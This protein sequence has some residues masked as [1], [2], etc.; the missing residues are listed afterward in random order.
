LR[1]RA[2]S[3]CR[4][5]ARPP[6]STRSEAAAGS[7]VC[8]KHAVF[9]PSVRSTYV[10]HRSIYQDRLGTSIRK[11]A[12]LSK[13]TFSAALRRSGL[14]SNGTTALGCTAGGK[15]GFWSHL[16]LKMMVLPRQARD[17]H[18]ENSKKARFVAATQ[19]RRRG[20]IRSQAPTRRSG[21]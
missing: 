13:R 7:G 4:A 8:G 17:K 18:R 11:R 5:G 20:S 6:H 2:F 12:S 16:Y 1:T 10:K 21:R 15:A 9:E 3:A 19:G 14:A